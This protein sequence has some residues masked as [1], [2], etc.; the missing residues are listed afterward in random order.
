MEITK[1]KTMG[2]FETLTVLS[3]LAL[4]VGC[5]SSSAGT[6][7][8]TSTLHSTGGSAAGGAANQSTGGT[9]AV[10]GGTA[11]TGGLG[12]T[13]TGN[14]VAAGGGS[15]A[16]G[17]VGGTSTSGS[18]AVGGSALAG[19]GASTQSTGGS[20]GVGGSTT[21]TGGTLNTATGGVAA[22]GGSGGTGDCNI[23][24]C[25]FNMYTAC[26]GPSTGACIEQSE[27]TATTSTTGTC[28]SNGTKAFSTVDLATFDTIMTFENGSTVCYS[29]E[30]ELTGSGTTTISASTYKDGSGNVVATGTWD[31]TTNVTTVTCTGGQPIVLNSACDDSTSVMLNCSAG[32]CTP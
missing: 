18:I 14:S 23:P 12:N 24:L 2:R 5:N 26:P 17:G 6:S 28:Y 15:A 25:L 9:A 32:V 20:L 1:D 3:T 19:G 22:V 10:S 29:Q 21:A 16:T 31:E 27:T 7:Q 13:S 30:I 11:A 4:I 8:D